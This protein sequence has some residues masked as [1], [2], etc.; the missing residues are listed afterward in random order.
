MK[1]SVTMLTYNHE[2]YIAQAIESVLMQ[3]VNF[4]YELI[5][6]EDGSI[7]NTPSIVS[8]FQDRYPHRI[9]LLLSEKNLGVIRN[10]RRVMEACRGEYIAH[11]D[12]DDYWTSPDKLQKQVDFLDTHPECA[13]CCHRVIVVSEDGSQESSYWPPP[14]QK[15]IS[16]VEDL[17]V[18]NFVPNCSVMYRRGL[19]E[20]PEWASRLK[21]PDWFFH[22]LNAQHGKLGYIDSVMA[23]YRIHTGAAW[24]MLLNTPQLHQ[25]Y[26][27]FYE[28]VNAYFNFRYERII[29]PQVIRLWDELAQ[30]L[31]GQGIEQGMAEATQ[32]NIIRI[33]D[34]WPSELPLPNSWKYRV[35]GRIYPALLFESY[36]A[37]DIPKTRYFWLRTIRYAPS[38]LRNRGVWAI[39][40]EAFLGKRAANWLRRGKRS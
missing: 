12:G 40:V 3:K 36:K 10:S 33:F 17:L 34:N 39:G 11:L 7:D 29:R 38:W 20:F 35:L 22:I 8:S 25:G 21:T 9:R 5:I 15:E 27:E 32:T 24:S 14:D 18:K 19:V 2:R 13:N 6:G 28:K 1:V 30:M 4:E 23:V 31:V 26:I 16:T 37:H